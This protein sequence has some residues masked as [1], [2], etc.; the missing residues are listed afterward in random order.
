M[1]LSDSFGISRS[2]VLGRGHYL[3]EL[4]FVIYKAMKETC[5]VCGNLV[6]ALPFSAMTRGTLINYFECKNCS[7]VQT[8]YPTWLEEA[9]AEPINPSDTG[10]MVRNIHNVELVIS[11]L[12][13]LGVR[14]GQVVDCAGGYGLLVRML[15]DKGINAFWSDQYASNL[16][17]RGFEYQ[18]GH[19]D[20]VTAFEAFE[21]FVNPVSEVERL[22]KIAPNILLTTSLIQSPAPSPDQWWYYGLEHGQHIG[23]FRVKTLAYL[24]RSLGLHL[25]SDHS[26]VHLLSKKP[27]SIGRWRLIRRIAQANLSILTKGMQSKTWDDHFKVAQQQLGN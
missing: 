15:R 5:R 7:Y 23:F 11:T 24:A 3:H 12:A 13:L 26:T 2:G 22:A 6:E 19:A 14:R 21:H 9:Y 17:C 25:V 1:G 4:F 18:G 8:Q 20:L 27:V 16:L 10:I